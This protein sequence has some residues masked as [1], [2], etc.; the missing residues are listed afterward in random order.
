MT[1]PA[2]AEADVDRTA[3]QINKSDLL[4]VPTLELRQG[5]ITSVDL[6]SATCSARIGGADTPVPLIKYLS[7][8]K[9][10]IGDTCVIL[11]NGTDMWALDRDGVFGSAVFAGYT[12][13]FIGTQESRTSTSYGDLATVGPTIVMN[14]PA[15]GS[16]LLGIAC[17]AQKNNTIGGECLM[18]TAS[19][20][21]NSWSA[22]T[23]WPVV[24]VGELISSGGVGTTVA[25]GSV[26][27]LTGLNP[28]L[29][30]ITAKYASNG[31]G[32]GVWDSRLIWAIPI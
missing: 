18:T 25:C 30:T 6:A 15:S 22:G 11:V 20:G 3:R 8:Y 13:Q 12:V 7:N 32:G 17:H 26:N 5:V 31:S 29:T 21:A 28:G 1:A 9:A 4:E 19:A 2:P 24:G 23:T 16:I 14:V 10:T 27:M